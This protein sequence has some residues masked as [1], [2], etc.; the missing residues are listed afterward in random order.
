MIM[1]VQLVSQPATAMHLA[2][3][4]ATSAE[5]KAGTLLQIQRHFTR[6]ALTS[7]SA[8]G[9][10]LLGSSKDTSHIG[11]PLDFC[12]VKCSSANSHHGSLALGA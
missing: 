2:M 1:H 8:Y 12:I 11:A 10:T 5:I 3:L 6:K 9:K 4:V 7:V